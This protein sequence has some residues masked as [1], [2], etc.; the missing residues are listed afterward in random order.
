MFPN[1]EFTKTALNG[2][3]SRIEKVERFIYQALAQVKAQVAD[4]IQ[5]IKNVRIES[6]GA[7]KSST[8]DWS[9]NDSN[10][11]DYVKN[12]THYVLPTTPIG[13]LEFTATAFDTI[14]YT[15]TS[16]EAEFAIFQYFTTLR[17]KGEVLKVIVGG[18]EGR[19]Q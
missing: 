2:L 5:D 9:Q 16:E 6:A 1:L 3:R 15:M 10:A 19:L 17:D 12:R 4:I 8:A 18:K 13:S 14:E 7:I 11:L